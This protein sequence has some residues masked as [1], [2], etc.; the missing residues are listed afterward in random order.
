LNAR[1]SKLPNRLN[2]ATLPDRLEEIGMLER[3]K[4]DFAEGN[5]GLL[6]TLSFG[7][8]AVWAAWD[9]NSSLAIVFAVTAALC[10]LGSYSSKPTS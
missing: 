8:L 3:M 6:Y 5:W 4:T 7:G 9:H 2:C 10:A 1:L